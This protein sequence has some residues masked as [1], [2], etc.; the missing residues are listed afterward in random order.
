MRESTKICILQKH[1]TLHQGHFVLMRRFNV[2][3]EYWASDEPVVVDELK[4]RGNEHTRLDV[5]HLLLGDAK[6]ATSANELHSA[7][8]RGRAKLLGLGIFRNVSFLVDT[9]AGPGHASV[10]VLADEL[11]RKG[12]CNRLC[13]TFFP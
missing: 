9:G 3:S 13:F 2:P 11:P 12:W 5:F 8:S 10:G 6:R 7:L 1:Q 4:I